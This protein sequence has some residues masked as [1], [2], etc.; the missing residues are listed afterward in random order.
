MKHWK[1]RK[2][3]QGIAL[4]ACLSPWTV[5]YA[6]QQQMLWGEMDGYT[7][8]LKKFSLIQT[9]PVPK[10]VRIP[11]NLSADN[12]TLNTFQFSSGFVDNMQ[13]SHARYDQYYQ[14]V[15]VWGMQ[16]IY[17]MSNKGT[18][19]T[20]DLVSGIEKDVK[21]L[22]G[23]LSVEQVEKI[24][25]GKNSSIAGVFVEKII[26]FD[27]NISKKA[28]L[29]Y[30]ASYGQNT[31]NGPTMPSF[32]IDA[33]T[34]K[35][36]QE[37]NNLPNLETGQGVGG[38]T[39]TRLPYRPGRYQFGNSQLGLNSLGML[40]ATEVGNNICTFDNAAYQY[41]VINLRNSSTPSVPVS[42]QNESHPYTYYCN[43]PI[44]TDNGTAPANDGV[45]PVGDAT[46]F[47]KQTMVMLKTQYG[48]QT[49]MN[50]PYP[51]RVFTHKPDYDNAFACS[52]RCMMGMHVIGPPQI[53]FGNGA[54][55]FSAMTEGDVVAHEFGHLV[56]DRYS[57]L[58]YTNQSGG[59]NEAFSDMT[60]LAI[61]SF[62]REDLGFKWYWNG[63]D[64][65][66]GQS[67]A[68]S[69]KPMRYF[70]NPE[71]DNRSIGNAAKYVPGMDPHLSSGVYNRLFYLI[72]TSP[73]W[74]IH[75][76]YQTMLDAN[77]TYWTPSSTFNSGACGILTAAQARGFT[78]APLSI[79]FAQVGIQ[80]GADKKSIAEV[81]N[82]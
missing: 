78:T 6:A 37:W 52:A 11:V 51:I 58:N 26:F 17:H 48:L 45:S 30:H 33:N 50:G 36:L 63:T 8:L 19:V 82:I 5:S 41:R 65:T 71:L 23:K 69:G 57:N 49:L 42:Y 66:T 29:A 9:T 31:A 61:N 27:E 70:Y 67:I 46:Y 39:I 22:K 47:I 15:P 3:L 73:N 12:N 44:L 40:D 32:I 35:I 62:V 20:G 79:A 60:G 1:L 74:T 18:A 64:W 38:V 56:T 13:K 16:I 24:A 34:G 72:S 53:I 55:L 59:M 54:T 75:M 81:A 76:G 21:D 10:G 28:T 43:L 7:A 14:G 77:T 4:S 68:K 2:L 25:L 80:C